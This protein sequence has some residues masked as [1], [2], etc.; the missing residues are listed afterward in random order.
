MFLEGVPT[1]AESFTTIVHRNSEENRERRA[2]TFRLM[3]RCLLVLTSLLAARIAAAEGPTLASDSFEYRSGGPYLLDGGLVLGFPTA[4]PTGMSKGAGAG[5]TFGTCPFRWGARAAWVTATESTR[6]WTVT[7]SDVR[8][9]LTGSAQQ[10]V[11]R[12]SFGIRLGLG[13]TLV[14]ETRLRN[15]GARAG[16]TGSELETSA[17]ALVPAGDLEAVVGLHLIGPWLLTV[18]GGPSLAVIDGSLHTSWTAQ[19]GVAWQP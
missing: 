9:R 19:L 6:V 5:I 11:G 15:Q 2:H 18:S 16:K 17:F 8:M 3:A 1:E 14:H 4:L 12:G 13:G 10:D 7:N